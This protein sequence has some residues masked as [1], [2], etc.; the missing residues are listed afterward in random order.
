MEIAIIGSGRVAFQMSKALKKAGHSF[1]YVSGRNVIESKKLATYLGA[2]YTDN[3]D[4]FISKVQLVLIAVNDDQIES[5]AAKVSP[6]F[7]GIVAHTSGAISMRVFSGNAVNPAIFYPLYSFHSKRAISFRK[8]PLLVTAKAS[9]VSST[10]LELAKTI[11][12]KT[13]EVSD[14]DRSKLHISAVFANNFTNF[15]MTQCFDLI[16]KEGLDKEIILPI[17]KQSAKNWGMGRAG[18]IQTGPAARGDHKTITKH[19]EQ[20]K[21]EDLHNMYKV[22]SENIEKYYK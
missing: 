5:V 3:F 15:M 4:D 7:S 10:L 11:T 12:T 14:S 16:E 21:N 9:E 22:I 19:L 18:D 17:I 2:N 6:K 8:I 20:L 13:Y 1:I